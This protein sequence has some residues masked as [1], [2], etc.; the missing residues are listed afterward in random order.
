MFAM[1]DDISS[2]SS[3]QHVLGI[4]SQNP[5]KLKKHHRSLTGKQMKIQ[6]FIQNFR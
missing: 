4:F 3:P 6:E 1:K 2:E 5:R